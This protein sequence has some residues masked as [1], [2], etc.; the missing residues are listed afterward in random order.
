MVALTFQRRKAVNDW[1][2]G[3]RAIKTS[4]PWG[5]RGGQTPSGDITLY[6]Q[7]LIGPIK[8]SPLRVRLGTTDSVEK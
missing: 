7:D 8:G 2:G 6:D 3:G 1:T 4:Q 5:Q